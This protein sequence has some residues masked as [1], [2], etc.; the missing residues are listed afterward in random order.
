MEIDH[1]GAELFLSYVDNEASIDEVWNHDA[2]KIIREHADKLRGG[3]EKEQIERAVDGG[4]SDYYGVSDIDENREKIEDLMDV[5]RENE[6]IWLDKI[7]A[8][9]D[10]VVQDENKDITIYPVFGF[11][12]GI[13]LEDGV[14]INLNEQL[15][16]DDPCH[17]IYLAIHESSHALYSRIHGMPNIMEVE[18][19]EDR[20]SFFN[21]FFHSEGYAVYTPLKSRKDDGYMGSK[22][23][24]ITQDYYE[25]SAE[26]RIK[27]HVKKY[28]KLREDLKDSEDWS[29]EKYMDRAFG[30]ERLAYRVGCTM[31]NQIEKEK[32]MDEVRE[33]FYLDADE[34]VEKYDWVLDSYR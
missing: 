9:L 33:A 7:E 26:D 17:F 18:S 3:L 15:F 1:S 29:L 5:I 12:I 31:I 6:K 10:R 24:Y 13:G 25:L 11:D 20:I 16:F 34:F 14:C 22:G 21:T 8:E 27:E 32:G 2:Y 4:E 19:A 30:E 23:H 28:D